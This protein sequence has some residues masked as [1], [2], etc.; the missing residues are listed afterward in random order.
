MWCEKKS[1]G[2]QRQRHKVE[3]GRRRDGGR[4]SGECMDV[5]EQRKKGEKH[6]SV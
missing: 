2:K 5:G 1:E 3:G 6:W 4:E